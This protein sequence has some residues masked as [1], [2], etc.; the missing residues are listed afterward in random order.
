MP[1][2]CKYMVIRVLKPITK[3]GLSIAPSLTFA[4]LTSLGGP[5][6]L[7]ASRIRC[8][9][10]RNTDGADSR[11]VH[12]LDEPDVHRAGLAGPGHRQAACRNQ[13][14][15]DKVR[16]LRSRRFLF[17][18]PNPGFFFLSPD[19]RLGLC[20]NSAYGGFPK[21]DSSEAHLFSVR[22][23]ILS[24]DTFRRPASSGAGSVEQ[25]I[26]AARLKASSQTPSREETQR[27]T[28]AHFSP[29]GSAVTRDS[30]DR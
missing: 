6:G 3:V 22:R 29:A 27:E 9:G 14:A 7:D 10:F 26:H 21:G 11:L 13:H 4:Q 28:P 23:G 12:L 30:V 8:T 5:Y 20:L 2:P 24:I 18:N 25:P 1:N 17:R 16:R 15:R 19:F